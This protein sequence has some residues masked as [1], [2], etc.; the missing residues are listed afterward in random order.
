MR[1]SCSRPRVPVRTALTAIVLAAALVQAAPAAAAKTGHRA[2]VMSAAA[3][4]AAGPGR[5]NFQSALRAHADAD[6]E[7]DLRR[8]GAGGPRGG[9]QRQRSTGGQGSDPRRRRRRL[10]AKENAASTYQAGFSPLTPADVAAY[11][12][13]ASASVSVTVAPLLRL[14]L[15]SPLRAGRS[16][17]GIPGERIRISGTLAPFASGNVVVRVLKGGRQFVG[18]RGP[19]P[20]GEER[21]ASRSASRL[22]VAAST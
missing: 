17:V 15:S 8:R 22:A 6:R 10:Q 12:P 7:A 13:A 5:F 1:S 21:A 9:A 20:R 4:H 18:P 19:S 14:R 11:Q 3:P 16:I 2:A